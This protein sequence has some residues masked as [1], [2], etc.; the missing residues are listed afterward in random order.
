MRYA[1][2]IELTPPVERTVLIGSMVWLIVGLLLRGPDAGPDALSGPF[3]CL[4]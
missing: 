3:C 2:T 1:L 4:Q